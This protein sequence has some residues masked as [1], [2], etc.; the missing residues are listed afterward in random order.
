MA[1]I[2]CAVAGRIFDAVGHFEKVGTANIGV[3]SSYTFGMPRYGNT[4]ALALRTP[5]HLY[6]ERDAIPTVPPKWLGF[7]NAA[8][9]YCLREG[10]RSIAYGP[11]APGGFKSLMRRIRWGHGIRHHF[12][13]RYIRRLA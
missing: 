6:N 1:A 12:I 4:D 7:S 10:R 9:E 11:R 8:A 2:M 13:E 5:F 3:H